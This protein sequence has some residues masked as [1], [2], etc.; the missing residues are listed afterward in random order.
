MADA[1]QLTYRTEALREMGI[2][3]VRV[4]Q[5]EPSPLLRRVLEDA[6]EGE[7]VTILNMDELSE[8]LVILPLSDFELMRVDMTIREVFAY[9]GG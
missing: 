3:V 7:A 6:Q 5:V 4:E 8:P 2:E 9:L 1:L